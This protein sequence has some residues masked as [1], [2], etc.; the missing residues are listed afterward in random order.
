M[1]KRWG[2]NKNRKANTLHHA[3][4][5][6]IVAVS[7]PFRKRVSEYFTQRDKSF[8]QALKKMNIYFPQPWE[9]FVNELNVRLEQDPDQMKEALIK[10]DLYESDPDFRESVM[11]IFPSWMPKRSIKGQL[12]ESTFRRN[13]GK[14]EE[15]FTQVVTKTKLENI[16][17]DKN[18]D[19]SMYRK[20]FDMAT[21]N[22][23]KERYLEFEGN[24]EKAF[25][26]PLYKPSKSIKNAPVIRSVKIVDKRNL[27]VSVKGEDMIADNAS[28]ARTDVYQDRETKKYYLIPVYVADVKQGN[29]PDRFIA[30][31][32]PY[33]K[34]PKK[35][36]NHSYLFSLYSNDLIY[37]ELPKP[38]VTKRE[39]IEWKSGYFYFKGVDT[40]T[41][42]ISISKNDS[43]FS[44][45]IG[46]Q[47]LVNFSKYNITPI[48]DLQKVQKETAYGV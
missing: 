12:H 44:D 34:W 42:S 16:R 3:L 15:G 36:E 14:T 39:S 47:S 23:V 8:K 26:Q 13:R 25:E 20:E 7:R 35:A 22:A 5:A 24:K 19:F 38:K 41:G 32:K 40:A 28:I 6:A 1:R 11:P 9:G 46:V 17:F 27:Y 43:K 33:E 18:G 30:A 2:F 21:Y 37:I 48:G 31:Y 29:Q 10:S 45:R 4:D